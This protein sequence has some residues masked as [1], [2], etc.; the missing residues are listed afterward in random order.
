MNSSTTFPLDISIIGET[1]PE[2]KKIHEKF[3]ETMANV[4]YDTLLP[5]K[6][7]ILRIFRIQNLY[8]WQKYEK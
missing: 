2:Y 7:T 4:V 6:A 3:F 8:L 1:M 5:T